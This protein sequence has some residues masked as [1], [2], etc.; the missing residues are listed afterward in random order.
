[1]PI[2]PSWYDEEHSII[3]V[4]IPARSSWDEYYVAVNWIVAEMKTVDHRVDVIFYEEVG[5]PSGNP[6]P[7]LRW[8]TKQLMAL[9]NMGDTIVAG[10]KRN[11]TFSRIILE[12]V[13][14]S[15]SPFVLSAEKKQ[16]LVFLSG[17]KEALAHIY[18]KRKASS[19]QGE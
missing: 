10:K 4:D 13:G 11:N 14:K 17:L 9:P 3:K 5:M 2:E 1:M 16:E 7:H 8:G 12:T 19:P 15:F 6:I 18:D